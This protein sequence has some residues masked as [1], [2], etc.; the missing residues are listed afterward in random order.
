MHNIDNIDLVFICECS[1][2][3]LHAKILNIWLGLFTRLTEFVPFNL[4]RF[5]R[6]A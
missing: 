5:V 2:E 4:N 1:I 6:I 3:P